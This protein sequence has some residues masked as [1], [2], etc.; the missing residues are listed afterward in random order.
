M[1]A[2]LFHTGGHVMAMEMDAVCGKQIDSS[3]AAGQLEFEGQTYYF[4]SIVCRIKFEENPK[5]YAGD[6]A[7]SAQAVP[8]NSVRS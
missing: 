2:H 3:S 1:V 8:E 5:Q 6:R 4:C 7:Q